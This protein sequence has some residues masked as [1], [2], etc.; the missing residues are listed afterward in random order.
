MSNIVVPELKKVEKDSFIG[1]KVENNKLIFHYPATYRINKDNERELF[2]Q[3]KKILNTISLSSESNEYNTLYENNLELQPKSEVPLLAYM[4]IIQDYVTNGKYRNFEKVI[5][6]ENRGKINWKKTLQQVPYIQDGIP[7]YQ[8]FFTDHQS[9]YDDVIVDIYKNSLKIAIN[10]LG[11]L[12]DVEE[13]EYIKSTV[14]EYNNETKDFFLLV[15]QK[16]LSHTFNDK[17]RQRLTTMREIISGINITLNKDF[18]V[19][20]VDKYWPVFEYMLRSMLENIGKEKYKLYYPNTSWILED[21]NIQN[22]TP[23]RPDIIY[24][25]EGEYFLILDAKYYS[26]GYSHDPNDLPQSSDIM[27]QFAYSDNIKH[28]TG[29]DNVYNAFIMPFDN[30]DNKEKYKYIGKA[31]ASNKPNESIYGILIDLTHL[32]ENYS[33]KYSAEEAANI[34]KILNKQHFTNI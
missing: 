1:L 29:I 12:F 21:G 26:Y 23:L 2:S 17:K 14:Y 4:Y 7:I 15:I 20:G 11:W 24:E 34:Y 5:K 31:N 25:K 18:K 9:Q 6:N 27:K 16:E 19:Y 3:L 13:D 8:S 33:R 10:T 30:K 22:N 28:I 32:I